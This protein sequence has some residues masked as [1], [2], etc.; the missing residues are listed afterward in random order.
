M[1][2]RARLR[3][4]VESAL[5]FPSLTRGLSLGEELHVHHSRPREE[6]P[7]LGTP[8]PQAQPLVPLSPAG[9]PL[10]LTLG[11][12]AQRGLQYLVCLSVSQCVCP[13]L[14]LHCRQRSGIRAIPTAPAQQAIEN[15]GDFAKTKA[16]E[17]EKLALSRTTLRDPAHQLAV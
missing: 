6:V 15:N 9:L 10:F 12:H 8:T 5:P 1:D 2:A 4:G 14:F 17:I 3:S 11:A 13:R 7:P 16:F